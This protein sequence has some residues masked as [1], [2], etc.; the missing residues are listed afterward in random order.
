MPVILRVPLSTIAA[1]TGKVRAVF[2]KACLH[3]HIQTFGWWS[4]SMP[5]IRS[6]S[7]RHGQ[8]QAVE[9]QPT[10]ARTLWTAKAGSALAWWNHLIS[11]LGPSSALF[12]RSGASSQRFREMK[13]KKASGD[14]RRTPALHIVLRWHRRPTALFL[15]V[16]SFSCFILVSVPSLLLRPFSR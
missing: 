14:P 4:C 13:G 10:L 9:R 15:R 11:C 16:R 6:Y 8:T 3:I 7:E 2:S 12:A 1:S 5:V